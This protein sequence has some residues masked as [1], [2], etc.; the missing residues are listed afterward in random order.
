MRGKWEI[1][2]PGRLVWQSASWSGGA[3]RFRADDAGAKEGD[4]ISQRS[5]GSTVREGGRRTRSPRST[6][7]VACGPMRGGE[8]GSHECNPSENRIIMPW[9]EGRAISQSNIGE[10]FVSNSRNGL[11]RTRS[12][13]AIEWPRHQRRRP[14]F[15]RMLRFFRWKGQWET[16]ART[17][18]QPYWGQYNPFMERE[19]HNR[20]GE[21]TPGYPRWVTQYGNPVLVWV[22]NWVFSEPGEHPCK[23]FSV[24]W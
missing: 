18:K 4:L 6:G 2:I 20:T 5:S 9:R 14:R 24:L 8:K 23:Q 1:R 3:A 7:S 12:V 21:P 11:A 22:G 13:C 16:P 10:W 19:G 17:Q 15:S